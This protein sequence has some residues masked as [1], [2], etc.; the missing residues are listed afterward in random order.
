M[1]ERNYWG[2][3]INIKKIDFFRGELLNENRL[4]QGW[5]WDSRQDLRNFQMNEGAGRNRAM[6]NNVKKGDILLI[7]QLPEW[8]YVAIAEA[9]EDWNTGYRFEIAEN[10]GDF[11][12]IFPAKYLK[13]F[14]RSDEAVSGNIR[15]SLHNPSRFW[16]INHYAEDIEA[17]IAMPETELLKSMDLVDRFEGLVSGIFKDVFAEKE[18]AEGLMQ[19]S[20]QQFTREEWEFVLIHGLKKLFPFYEIERVGGPEEENHGTDILIK[21]PSIHPDYP[22]YAIAVQVKDWKGIVEKNRVIEQISKADDY[23]N[24]DY[25]LIDKILIFTGVDAND[26]KDLSENEQGVK[27][28]F[29]SQLKELLAMIGRKCVGDLMLSD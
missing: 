29:A 14:V 27:I 1:G 6:F 22:Q 5:G 11:G 7:P 9:T 12:H 24:R 28:I 23:W 3:R 20:N 8:G 19:K 17:I 10:H 2:Y 18:F 21:M 25:K 26:N 15:S 4:R 16:N 13:R